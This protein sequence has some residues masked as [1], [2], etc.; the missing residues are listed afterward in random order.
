MK[1]LP[2]ILVVL[3]SGCAGWVPKDWAPKPWAEISVEQAL[4]ECQHEIQLGSSQDNC[5]RA[6]GWEPVY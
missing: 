2:V 5:M 1:L 4:A 3:L 6:K